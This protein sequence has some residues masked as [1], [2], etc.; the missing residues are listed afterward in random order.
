MWL[1]LAALCTAQAKDTDDQSLRWAQVEARARRSYHIGWWAGF[2]GTSTKL[3]GTLLNYPQV[4]LGGAITQKS[5]VG[6]MLASGLRERR[7]VQ[8]LGGD[9]GAARGRLGLLMWGLSGVLDIGG[10]RIAQELAPLG[11]QAELD[12]GLEVAGIGATLASYVLAVSQHRRNQLASD[13]RS[14]SS[15]VEW[16]VQPVVSDTMTGGR[17]TGRF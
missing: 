6:L 2:L 11:S 8:G 3:G 1:L 16:Q 12:L 10:P 15:A 7:A 13:E 14:R 17:V 4:E 5:G 9:I